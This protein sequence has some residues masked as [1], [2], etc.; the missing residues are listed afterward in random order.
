MAGMDIQQLIATWGS[1]AG[2]LFILFMSILAVLMPLIVY[3]IYSNTLKSRQLLED[4]DQNISRLVNLQI[5]SQSHS[6]KPAATKSKT[7][8]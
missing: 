4:I 8:G 3:L 2:I 1:A 7:K 6:P 5:A